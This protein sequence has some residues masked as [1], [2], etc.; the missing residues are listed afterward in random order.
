MLPRITDK[1]LINSKSYLLR[2]NTWCF[3]DIN[4]FQNNLLCLW[5]SYKISSH[6]I[7]NWYWNFFGRRNG[8]QDGQNKIALKRIKQRFSLPDVKTQSH[9]C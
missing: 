7:L 5:K 6:F 9:K 3:K 2:G 8:G 1:F 4:P